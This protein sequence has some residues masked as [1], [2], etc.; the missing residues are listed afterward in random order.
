MNHGNILVR[1]LYMINLEKIIDSNLYYLSLI[2]LLKPHL[3]KRLSDK[4]KEM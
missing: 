2:N 1:D 4:D 3:K